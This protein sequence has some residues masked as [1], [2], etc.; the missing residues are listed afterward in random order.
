MFSYN[1][2]LFSDD[3]VVTCSS[4]KTVKQWGICSGK[5]K[6]INVIPLAN[7][8]KLT[9]WSNQQVIRGSPGFTCNCVGSI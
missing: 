8:D 1:S 4:D 5:V 7:K 2:L 3:K 9:D 6:T